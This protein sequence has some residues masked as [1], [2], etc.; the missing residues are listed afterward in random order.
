LGI[1]PVVRQNSSA[2]EEVLK[3]RRAFRGQDTRSQLD[4]VIQAGVIGQSEETLAGAGL[5]VGCAIDNAPNAG[6]D[7]RAGAH[8]AR[9]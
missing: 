8:R 7:D 4:A 3:E 1:R 6:Q 2:P 5:G 9:L